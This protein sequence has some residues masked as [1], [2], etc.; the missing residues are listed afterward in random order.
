MV[1]ANMFGLFKLFQ[2]NFCESCKY[3]GEDIIV[4]AMGD[5]GKSV[6]FFIQDTKHLYLEKHM[7]VLFLR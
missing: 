2:P 1:N 4:W 3:Y 7:C 5:V 6:F